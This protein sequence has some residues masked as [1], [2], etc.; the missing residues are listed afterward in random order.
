MAS[1]FFRSMAKNPVQRKVPIFD[2][3]SHRWQNLVLKKNTDLNFSID[4]S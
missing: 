2:S 3:L 4:R 1:T